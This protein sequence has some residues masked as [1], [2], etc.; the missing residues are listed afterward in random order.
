MKERIGVVF[1]GKSV[2]HEVSIISALQVMKALKEAEYEVIPFYITNDGSWLTGNKL[3][4][5]D[6]FKPLSKVVGGKIE[7]SLSDGRFYK[8]IFLGKQLLELDLL[9]PMVHGTGGEDGTLPG[10]FELINLP[11]VGCGITASALGMD[12]ILTKI[13][14]QNKGIPTLDF[15]WFVQTRWI[16]ERVKLL[17]EI[18]NRFVFPVVVKPG[19]LGSSIG[20]SVVNNNEELED[21]IDLAVSLSEKILIE[22]Y[23]KNLREFNCSVLGDGEDVLVS[24]CE[25]PLKTAEI[26]SY[27]DKYLKGGSKKS[28]QRGMEQVQRHLPAKISEELKREIQLYAKQAF[29]EIGG[30]GVVRIDFMWDQDNKQLYFGEFNTIPGSLAFYLWE[31]TGISFREL[32]VRLVEL[33]KKRF[34]RKNSLTT[35]YSNNIFG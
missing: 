13:L 16:N 22:P 11:Y 4:Q 19:I 1:G 17:E 2:E 7:F 32:V 23:I 34:I 8:K 15:F 26:L 3:M 27:Q 30:S 14:L 9:F 25:E 20:I 21:A 18:N 12:K 29:L 10:F 24:E 6:S 5:L 35:H 28:A 31:A 33:A